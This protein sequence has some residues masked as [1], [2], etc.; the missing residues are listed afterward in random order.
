MKYKTNILCAVIAACLFVIMP[1]SSM[2]M[3]MDEVKKETRD[4]LKA[5]SDYS[6]DQRDEAVRRAKESLDILDKRIDALE[7]SIDENWDKMDAAAREK[8]RASLKALHRQ[9][10]LVAEWYG[11]LK[12]STGEAWGHMKKGFSDTY[13][14]LSDAWA[15]SVKEFSLGI[16]LKPKDSRLYRVRINALSKL[17]RPNSALKDINKAIALKPADYRNYM[18]RWVVYGRKQHFNKAMADFNKALEMNPNSAKTYFFRGLFNKRQKNFRMA[19]QDLEKACQMGFYMACK[20]N[21]M[22]INPL[23][24][25]K[26]I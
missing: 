9:R 17:G 4:L 21:V 2:A 1:L 22:S 3:S 20:K 6:I 19:K 13:K 24:R 18:I 5:I 26:H 16:K 7:A 14:A 15:K 11:S 25:K 10:T 23:N 8:A 12:N